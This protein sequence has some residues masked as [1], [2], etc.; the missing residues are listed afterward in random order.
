[1]SETA[2]ALK[3]SLTMK[4][5]GIPKKAV[6]DCSF[7]S[8][9]AI[10]LDPFQA[11]EAGYSTFR[12]KDHMVRMVHLTKRR[13]SY[14]NDKVFEYEPLKCRPLGHKGNRAR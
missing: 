5:K 11:D 1:M 7:E 9:E 10:V 14:N 2:L 6:K 12:S 3:H 13:F 4:T 8:M